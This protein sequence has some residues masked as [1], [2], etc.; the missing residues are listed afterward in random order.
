MGY[1]IKT[2]LMNM[3]R[4]EPPRYAHTV[5][6]GYETGDVPL[7]GIFHVIVELLADPRF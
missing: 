6:T 1:E 7:C 5:F 2:F 4:S 3:I